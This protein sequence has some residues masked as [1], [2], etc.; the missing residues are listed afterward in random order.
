MSLK[1]YVQIIIKI[2]CLPW[3]EANAPKVLLEVGLV[4]FR[5]VQHDKA[6]LIAAP[7]KAAR[8]SQH[9]PFATSTPE[10]SRDQEDAIALWLILWG[11]SPGQPLERP[12][13][14]HTGVGDGPSCSSLRQKSGTCIR[15]YLR[16]HPNSP[17]SKIRGNVDAQ[18]TC[19]QEVETP[20][21]ALK[22][23]WFGADK[24]P[25]Q[26]TREN[27]A[28]PIRPSARGDKALGLL[29][30]CSERNVLCPVLGSF[31]SIDHETFQANLG[32]IRPD[33]LKTAVEKVRCV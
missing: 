7:Q 9:L 20:T 14:L 5:L 22:V 11:C 12:I 19:S 15:K 1:S 25:T 30:I 10:V 28:R 4:G 18:I 27:D 26:P 13:R 33:R 31:R 6:H 2:G 3:H 16:E 32:R 21:K 29:V 8:D 23:F 24:M 17:R